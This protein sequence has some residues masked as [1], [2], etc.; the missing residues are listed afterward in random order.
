[1]RSGRT[2]DLARR[3]LEHAR[4]PALK[5]LDLATAH[6]T[7]MRAEQRGLEQMLHDQYSP[8]LNAIRPISPGNPKLNDYMDAARRFLGVGE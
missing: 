2:N 8:P 3:Q 7:D 5:D 1:M 6:R 4:D